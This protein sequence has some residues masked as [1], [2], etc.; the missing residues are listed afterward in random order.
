MAYRAFI[1]RIDCDVWRI[2]ESVE[3]II[4]TYDAYINLVM[5]LAKSYLQHCSNRW[6]GRRYKKEVPNKLSC[7]LK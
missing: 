6:C 5:S 4:S 3:Y 7:Y 2:Y 1:L